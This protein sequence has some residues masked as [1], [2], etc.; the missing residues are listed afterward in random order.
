MRSDRLPLHALVICALA[1]ILFAAPHDS[2]AQEQPP[3]TPAAADATTPTETIYQP[4]SVDAPEAPP[5]GFT[6][7]LVT[8]L[9]GENPTDL[10]LLSDGRLLI[11][12]KDGQVRVVSGGSLVGAPALD[13]AAQGIICS[14]FER[15]LQSIEAD[16]NFATNNY[17]YVYHT[18]NDGSGGSDCGGRTGIVN[19]VVRY[20]LSAS[21]VMT[22]PAII[23]NNIASPCGNHNGGD[24][25]FGADGL[26]YIS[27]GDGGCQVS[28]ATRNNARYLGL[29]NGKILRVNPDGS[30]PASNPFVG[31]S[32]SVVCNTNTFNVNSGAC[33]ETFAWGFRNPFRFA[34][35]HGTNQLYVNDVG[36][37]AWE[38][39]SDVTAGNDYGWNCREGKNAFNCGINPLP[40]N[41]VDPLYDYAHA[42]GL[43][44][45]T[46]GAFITSGGVWPAPYNDAYF[47]GDYCGSTIYRLTLSGGTY[48]RASFGTVTGGTIVSLLFDP[49]A[50]ALYYTANGGR[51]GRITYTGNSNRAPTAV[52]SANPTSGN[53]PL[54]VQFNGSGSSD[55]DTGQTLTYGWNF[56]NGASST[57]ANPST[58]YTAAGTFTAT[59]V[60]TDSLGLASQPSRVTIF[61]GNQPP[62]PQILTPLTST[63]FSVGQAITLTGSATDPQ[64][65]DVTASLKWNVLLHHVPFALTVTQHTHPFFSGA[66]NNLP[67]PPMPAPE[68]LDAAPL[69]YL[70]IQLTATDS[71]GLTRTV[72]QTLQPNRVPVTFATSPNGL[73]LDVNSTAITATQTITSW[74]GYVLNVSTPLLQRDGSGQ[75]WKF[76]AWSDGGAASHVI[77]TTASAATYTAAFEK[78]VPVGFS[79]LP[80]V[81]K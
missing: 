24:L 75:W 20:T 47:F 73:R 53:A 46:G 1:A 4:D 63:R 77:T 42:S 50:D 81:M 55:P 7:T 51:V 36:Q 32:G 58:T 56:G 39:I 41:M 22:A 40:P 10:A 27:T 68:D 17:V 62:Q 67:M 33:R 3:T 64:D 29:L 8:T 54:T 25:Q 5:A 76:A 16:P 61:S 52:A 72:T 66:G 31:T 57:Q 2:L 78:F 28:G 30:V 21:N 6:D 71:A 65:G 48:G 59:L 23:L 79:N 26:L 14:E 44:S 45:I 13:L 43:C 69:S 9:S 80:I 11:T 49:T 38:E 35:R 60:V 70:E 37:N 34:V 74:Q 18:Y 15:G 19:R 12:T